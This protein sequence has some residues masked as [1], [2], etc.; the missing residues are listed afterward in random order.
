M[1]CTHAQGAEWRQ[2]RQE[3]EKKWRA[4]RHVA[5]TMEKGPGHASFFAHTAKDQPV[6][7]TGKVTTVQSDLAERVD[8]FHTPLPRGWAGQESWGRIDA[9]IQARQEQRAEAAKVAMIC[10]SFCWCRLSAGALGLP[11]PLCVPTG[12]A[13]GLHRSSRWPR[14]LPLAVWACLN[15][16]A[17]HV[18]A[19]LWRLLQA[20]HCAL[21][22]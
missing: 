5:H 21:D 15:A 20:L 7:S 13:A 4:D 14:P 9:A 22:S 16:S 3:L 1:S 11:P 19:S 12:E 17:A 2:K 8:G 18:G 6:P 10:L